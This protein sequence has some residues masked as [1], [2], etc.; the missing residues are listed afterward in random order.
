VAEQSPK[1]GIRQ[2]GQCEVKGIKISIGALTSRFAP[3]RAGLD[4]G[5]DATIDG[6]ALFLSLP[7]PAT[8]P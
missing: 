3:L 2:F 5:P 4:P 8:T 1:L 6:G 7:G